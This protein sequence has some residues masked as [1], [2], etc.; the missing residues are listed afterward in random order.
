MRMRAFC[1]VS[2]MKQ[3][4]ESLASHIPEVVQADHEFGVGTEFS[5]GIGAVQEG[6]EGGGE[7]ELVEN[8]EVQ[9]VA[10]A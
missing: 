7:E 8:G 3:G 1:F 9:A 6:V 2:V 10:V 4:L 5:D